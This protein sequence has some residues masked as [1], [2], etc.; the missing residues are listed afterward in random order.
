MIAYHFAMTLVEPL[1]CFICHT[2]ATY[3]V[4][5]RRLADSLLGTNKAGTYYKPHT[6]YF[7]LAACRW[8]GSRHV[9]RHAT[10]ILF[11]RH[12]FPCHAAT[13]PA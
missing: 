11:I 1:R 4:I 5:I 3:H 6:K 12:A 7:Q 9:I 10:T 13:T 2:Y 8:L